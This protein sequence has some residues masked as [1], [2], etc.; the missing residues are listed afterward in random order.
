MVNLV[1]IIGAIPTHPAQQ[2][3][4]SLMALGSLG[5]ASPATGP[6]FSFV[7]F[8]RSSS[9]V[10]ERRGA[11]G[12]YALLCGCYHTCVLIDDGINRGGGCSLI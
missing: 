7:S 9:S 11:G 8:S 1:L 10:T 3:T 12:P 4:S 5:V 6:V 2:P